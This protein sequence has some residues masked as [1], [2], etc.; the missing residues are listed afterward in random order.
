MLYLIGTGLYYIN[1][2]PLRAVETLKACGEVFLERYTNPNDVSNIGE[3]EKII[4]KKINVLGRERVESDLLVEKAAEEDV[5]LLVPG[6]PLAATTHMSLIT[7]ACEKGI[8][9]RIIH[10]S[11]I[12]SAIGE[13][14]LSLY[15]FGGTASIPIYSEGYKPESFFD[16]IKMNRK[17]GMHT[18]VLLEARD[19]KNF[20]DIGKAAETLKNIERKRGEK[21]LDWDT[22]M[23][24]SRLGS[25]QQEIGFVKGS[26]NR[27][28]SPPVCLVIPGE[29]SDYEKEAVRALL[30]DTADSK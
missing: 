16:V 3:L 22:I 30:A 26:E 12:F 7:E 14:G 4:G 17:D 9:Y 24:A 18:L 13:T 27:V 19:E 10:S 1:D 11:S 21:I 20:L 29:M 25:E 15:K 8:K 23:F 2:L 28:H 5:C 6:D